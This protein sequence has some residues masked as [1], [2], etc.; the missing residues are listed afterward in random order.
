MG[1]PKRIPLITRLRSGAWGAGAGGDMVLSETYDDERWESIH[2]CVK[3][4][5]NHTPKMALGKA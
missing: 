3:I 1:W 5:L 4:A 2:V